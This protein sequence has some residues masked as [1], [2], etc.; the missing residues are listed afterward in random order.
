MD[1]EVLQNPSKELVDFLAKRI[2]E[3][4]W[5]NWEI[6]ERFPLAVQMKSDDGQVLAGAAGR[7]FG[8]WFLL[9]TLWVSDELRGKR[10]GSK[11]LSTIENVARERGCTKCYLETLNFQAMP[12]YEKHGYQTQWVQRDYPNTGCQYFMVKELRAVVQA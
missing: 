6:K 4:N 12:F 3:L 8:H 1:L 5:E 7:S 9:D 10:I 2:E 11:L